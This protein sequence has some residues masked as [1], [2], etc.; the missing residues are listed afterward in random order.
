MGNYRIDKINYELCQ[1]HLDEWAE[2]L[3]RYKMVKSYASKVIDYAI[4]LEYIETNPFEKVEFSKKRVKRK[5]NNYYLR[6]Q[7]IFFKCC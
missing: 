7:L 4:K 5:S 6:E 3:T 1:Q 2:K